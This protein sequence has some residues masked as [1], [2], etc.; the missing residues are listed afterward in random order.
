M[1]TIGSRVRSAMQGAG[2][3]QKQLAER[4][5]MTPDALSRALNGQRGFAALELAD[6]ASV[7]RV[8]V[9]FLITGEPDPHRLV[10]S[11][12]HSYDQETRSRSVDGLD[13]D[14]AI[15]ED[16]RL[17]YAQAGPPPPGVALP[18]DVEQMRRL[19]HPAFVRKFIDHLAE[20]DVDVVRIDGVSTA[21]S[22]TVEGRPVIVLPE[23]GNWFY[24]NWSLA[25][26]LGHL[27]LGHEGVIAGS[28]AYDA[29]ERAANAFAAELL[30]PETVMRAQA[31]PGM[32]LA[33]VAEL[34]WTWG[35]STD[36]LRRRLNALALAPCAEVA[37][38]LAGTTQ[39]LLRRHW[40]GARIGDPI[41]GRMRE[42]G[43][44]RFPDWLQEAH[45]ERI[46]DGAVGKGT[47]AWMLGV[48]SESLEV[49]EPGRGAELSDD[50][51]DA[52]L[53]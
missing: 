9:H 7:L 28:E 30:L 29:K 14:R 53:G 17:A 34:V 8:D 24:E 49:D 6:I 41:S 18:S 32:D 5:G 27:V 36:A 25:H 13:G 26:E 19:L 47:L 12:R 33:A 42:A 23:S 31:W 1:T 15:L 2:M 35:V 48:P 45:L 40:T 37:D 46:A 52:L 10:L 38:A 44:R 3:Q 22:F 51:L 20:L 43:E 21:Y 50:A 39:K 11:A 16:I 4:V